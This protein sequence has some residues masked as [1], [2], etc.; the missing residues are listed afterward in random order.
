M[1]LLLEVSIELKGFGN[2]FLLGGLVAARE[3]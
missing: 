2:V 1:A 3:E